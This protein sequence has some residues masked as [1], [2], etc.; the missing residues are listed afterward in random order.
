MTMTCH[1]T[2]V[3][4]KIILAFG[5][6][7]MTLLPMSNYAA[8]SV[9]PSPST[10]PTTAVSTSATNHQSQ[11]ASQQAAPATNSAL[12]QQPTTG[13][14]ISAASQPITPSNTIA[15][16][17][18]SPQPAT[19]TTTVTKN[20]DDDN[21]PS[22][23]RL[24]ATNAPLNQPNMKTEAVM[25][26]A[27]EAVKA[28]YSYDFRNYK[29][30]IQDTQKYFTNSGWKAFTEALNKSNNLQI[31]E[32]KKLV[33]SAVT[34]KPT[35][36]EEGVKKGRYTWKVQMPITASYENESKLIK[37]NLIVTLLIARTNTPEGVGISHFIAQIVPQ[38][39]QPP[40]GQPGSLPSSP[41]NG[42]SPSADT[43]K[44]VD[45]NNKSLSS[46]PADNNV[47][48]SAVPAH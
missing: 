18:A 12:S 45:T 41:T 4:K 32:N 34:T 30:Q 28:V 10:P 37:Q 21:K 24:V 5:T 1:R 6:L 47:S 7:V 29:K 2:N 31:V 3:T 46:T 14:Q 25:S 44:A 13:T 48:G 17:Q 9:N 20:G 33:A 42:N 40:T 38:N 39:Q 36:I 22:A 23:N 16:N 43:P 15:A 35:L 19:A 26:W 27:E 11:S 8:T